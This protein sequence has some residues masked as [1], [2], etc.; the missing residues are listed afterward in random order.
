MPDNKDYTVP[1]PTPFFIIEDEETLK[2][3]IKER[4]SQGEAENNPI[5]VAATSHILTSHPEYPFAV[6]GDTA[7]T[8]FITKDQI[9]KIYHYMNSL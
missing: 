7:F 9:D 3:Y 6:G 4:I 1:N 5:V 2:S 8:T